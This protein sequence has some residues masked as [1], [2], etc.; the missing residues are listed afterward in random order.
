MKR[1][2]L[3]AVVLVVLSAMIESS[4]A[5]IRTKDCKCYNPFKGDRNKE[6]LGD[7]WKLCKGYKNVE[8]RGCYVLNDTS[9][10]DM[11]SAAGGDRYQSKEACGNLR[12]KGVD[13]RYSPA[14]SVITCFCLS[15]CDGEGYGS[16]IVDRY[17]DCNDK[18]WNKKRNEKNGNYYSS[19][20][21]RIN[22]PASGGVHG[23][24]QSGVL[25]LHPKGPQDYHS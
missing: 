8:H 21:C 14:Q 16:C 12:S 10:N 20:A 7:P 22:K 25:A 4:E 1:C 11:K 9:C 24:S 13:Y 19:L 3:M 5:G 18:K 23:F 17:S 2:V 15:N 6:S